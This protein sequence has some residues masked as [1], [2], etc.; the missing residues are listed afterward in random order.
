MKY[1]KKPVVI[2]AVQFTKAMAEGKDSLP[3]GVYFC[4]RELAAN[5]CF[6]E[7]MKDHWPNYEGFHRHTI[8]TLEGVM[9]VQIGDWIIKGIKGEFYPSKPDIF[10]QTYEPVEDAP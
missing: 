8:E 2:E 5:G 6:P 3:D 1:R 4:R 7:I 10:E 9:Q